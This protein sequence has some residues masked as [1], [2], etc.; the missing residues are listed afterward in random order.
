VLFFTLRYP[1]ADIVAV[2]ASPQLFPILEANVGDLPGVT[3]RHAAVSAERGDVVFYEG[4]S[5][6]SGSTRS[7]DWVRSA[8]ETAV[9]GIPL[10][11][12]LAESPPDLVK[13]DI[14]GGEFD[15]LPTSERLAE[16]ET[17]LG[18]IHAPPESPDSDRLL[19]LFEGCELSSTRRDPA[20]S[21]ASTVFSA[22]RPAPARA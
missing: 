4:T 14:E 9:E 16:V 10:D 17:V 21:Q 2:E 20:I 5:S 12:L 19:A 1:G 15:V 11:E 7:G 18:E 22:F 3:L 6:W 13:I 8:T